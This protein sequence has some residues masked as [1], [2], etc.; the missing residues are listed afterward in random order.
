MV[1]KLL[2][3]AAMAAL[4][5]VAGPPAQSQIRYGSREPAPTDF[6]QQADAAQTRFWSVLADALSPDSIAATLRLIKDQPRSGTGGVTNFDDVSAPCVFIDTTPL[7]GVEQFAAFW[8]PSPNGGAILNG[9][10]NFGVNPHS[11]PNFLAFNNMSSYSSGIPKAPELIVVGRSKS[12]VSL[13]LSSGTDST[14]GYLSYPVGLIAIGSGGFKGLVIAIT[15]YTWQQF[16]ITGVGIEAID[17]VGN[18]PILLVDD[19]ESQ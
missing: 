5:V 3:P 8:A 14:G 18:P 13:W 16:T 15:D 6:A 12:S 19:I 1:R 17:V 2:A 9:C 4:L 7:L 10:S 11:W